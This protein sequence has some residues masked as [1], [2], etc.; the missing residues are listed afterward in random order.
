MKSTLR[1][2]SVIQARVDAFLKEIFDIC[3][4]S[5]DDPTTKSLSDTIAT[6]IAIF[7]AV[8]T[9][10]RRRR[11]EH[12]LF[13]RLAT[14]IVHSIFGIA[15]DVDRI[16][17][18]DLPSDVLG[19]NRHQLEGMRRVP[20]AWN[21][22]LLSSPKYWQVVDI[23]RPAKAIASVIERSGSAP[24]CVC[25]FVGPS[26]ASSIRLVPATRAQTLRSND[27]KGYPL[28]R[29]FLQNTI[30]VLQTLELRA[31]PWPSD[32][33][34]ESLGNLPFIRHL[35]AQWWQPPADAA[36]F[37]GL[38]EL[39][40]WR[41]L[42]PD[43][44][45][46]RVLSACTNLERLNIFSMDELVVGEL[47]GTISPITLPRLRSI[48]LKFKSSGSVVKLIRRLIIPQCLRRTL[49]VKQALDIGLYVADYGRFISLEEGCSGQYPNSADVLIQ[50]SYPGW[51]YKTESRQLV[52]EAL[53]GEEIPVHHDLVR[54][55]QSALKGPSLTV[56]IKYQSE[57]TWLFLKYFG[58]QN[59]QTIVVHFAG[60]FLG[61]VD[62]LK[63]IGAHPAH[64]SGP[65]GPM[66]NTATDWPFKSLRSIYIHDT[67]VKLVEFTGLVEEHLHKNSRPLLEEIVFVN[68]NLIGMELAQAAE[69]LAA[70]GINLQGV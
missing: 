41:T 12:T 1:I 49:H 45:L 24:L 23:T 59:V 25:S 64:P 70:I 66:A 10:I 8:E 27:V 44:E 36:W 18:P 47:S 33:P 54:E 43:M 4:S 21:N 60:Q 11:N 58:D 31:S 3:E 5:E 53:D 2:I 16:H 29:R 56:T 62:L 14:D 51:E 13:S 48:W 37:I 19:D 52:L 6:E 38:K 35:K 7:D 22:F 57:K 55:F 28:Y 30:P 67:H 17:D 46:L 34:I 50:G 20:S 63:A 69:R 39:V 61:A 68:C 42:E 15:L 40:L 32:D 65:D 9:V 26:R